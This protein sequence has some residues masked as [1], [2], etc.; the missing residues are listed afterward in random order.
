M[1]SILHEGKILQRGL[2]M[3]DGEGTNPDCKNKPASSRD[4]QKA[5]HA[6]INLLYE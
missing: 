1:L 4:Q 6:L 3:R 5:G 2:S